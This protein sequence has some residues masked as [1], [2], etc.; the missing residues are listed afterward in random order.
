MIELLAKNQNDRLN[1]ATV[2]GLNAG[3]TANQQAFAQQGYNQMQPINV[4]N[5]LRTG[6]QVSAPN[7]VNPAQQATTQGPDLLGAAGQQYNAQLAQTNANNA[8]SSG[9]LGGL[10]NMGAAYLGAPTTNVYK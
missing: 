10:M 1:Q 3:L 2:Q 7:W 4:I 9:F 6:S 8:A 5:A